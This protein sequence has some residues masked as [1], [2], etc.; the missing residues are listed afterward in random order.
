MAEN[1]RS[2]MMRQLTLVLGSLRE[3]AIKRLSLP[4]CEV[5][6]FINTVD[7]ITVWMLF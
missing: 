5:F 6:E 1:Y 4:T 2:T 7:P 3:L